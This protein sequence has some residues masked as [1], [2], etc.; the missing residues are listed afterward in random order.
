MDIHFPCHYC[1]CINVVSDTQKRKKVFC[2]G[3][4]LKISVPS[5]NIQVNEFDKECILKNLQHSHLLYSLCPFCHVI[6]SFT[7]KLGNRCV[8]CPQCNKLFVPFV[9]QSQEEYE[10]KKKEFLGQVEQEKNIWMEQKNQSQNILDTS[11]V[12]K[13]EDLCQY[14]QQR[15]KDNI[16][17]GTKT[18]FKTE[19]FSILKKFYSKKGSTIYWITFWSLVACS[20]IGVVGAI[21]EVLFSVVKINVPTMP[22]YLY[23]M[24]N[25][26]IK[27]IFYC[28]P[29]L[30]LSCYISFLIHFVRTE[31]IEISH[32]F[33]PLKN[34]SKNLF[35]PLEI[36]L[37]SIWKTIVVGAGILVILAL[38]YRGTFLFHSKFHQL[39]IFIFIILVIYIIYT[40]LYFFRV[41]ASYIFALFF[42]IENPQDSISTLLSKSCKL[43]KENKQYIKILANK[44]SYYVLGYS[45]LA[46]FLISM[47]TLTLSKNVLPYFLLVLIN[48]TATLFCTAV[49]VHYV[50]ISNVV[51]FYILTYNPEQEKQLEDEST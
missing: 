14:S 25:I 47:I 39:N 18:T 17:L 46:I 8:P 9:Y 23:Y 38:Y 44:Q 7:P 24:I 11:W 21:A 5:S 42:S 48:H 3:C 29:L 12:E 40:F 33:K 10:S 19:F 4:N 50:F 41:L 31:K 43:Y 35:L 51:L 15:V 45:M 28:L 26:M 2:Q 37:L 49:W 22:L 27:I 30:V 16:F 32:F 13:Y 34:I 6:Q 20:L 1:Q 36:F